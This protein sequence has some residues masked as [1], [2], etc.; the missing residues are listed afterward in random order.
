MLSSFNMRLTLTA[1]YR[2]SVVTLEGVNVNYEI[3]TA[4]KNQS[5]Y[6]LLQTQFIRE[7]IPT[8][9]LVRYRVVDL[10]PFPHKC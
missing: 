6:D 2:A 8:P 5:Q 9:P 4:K 3:R 1:K 10:F 7:N